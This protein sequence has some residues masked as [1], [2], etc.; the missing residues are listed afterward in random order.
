MQQTHVILLP[1]LRASSHSSSRSKVYAANA[2]RCWVAATCQRGP[3]AS[4][5]EPIRYFL[6]P[7]LFEMLAKSARLQLPAEP[8]HV[9]RWRQASLLH[10]TLEVHHVMWVGHL[11]SPMVGRS[12]LYPSPLAWQ[13]PMTCR[14]LT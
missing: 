8:F 7:V 2:E 5:L 9:P 3:S 13:C 10:F 1:L 6:D 4:L 14:Q 12:L 11:E